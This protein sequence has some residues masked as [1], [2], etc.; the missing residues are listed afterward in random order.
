MAKGDPQPQL[1][2]LAE[3]ADTIGAPTMFV[4]NAPGKDVRDWW[5]GEPAVTFDVAR[6]ISA[7]YYVEKDKADAEYTPAIVDHIFDRHGRVPCSGADVGTKGHWSA[8]VMGGGFR[9]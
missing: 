6:D 9:A 1:V 8:S 7:R 4:A 5:T 3:V 2:R